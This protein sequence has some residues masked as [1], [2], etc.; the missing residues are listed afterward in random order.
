MILTQVNKAEFCN[1]LDLSVA[2]RIDFS[3]LNRKIADKAVP[4]ITQDRLEETDLS[5]SPR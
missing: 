2:P 3:F 4:A 1:R 5:V